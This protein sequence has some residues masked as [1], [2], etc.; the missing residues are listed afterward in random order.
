M[1]A[2]QSQFISEAEDKV[3]VVE[4]IPQSFDKKAGLQ[5]TERQLTDESFSL[6]SEYE[7]NGGDKR[8]SDD[9]SSP[10][11]SRQGFLPLRAVVFES[12]DSRSINSNEKSIEHFKPKMLILSSSP[13]NSR[14][15]DDPKDGSLQKGESSSGF[16]PKT[17]PAEKK[18]PLAPRNQNKINFNFDK[19][20]LA[21]RSEK[22]A[23]SVLNIS[24]TLNLP[25]DQFSMKISSVRSKNKNLKLS[26]I[27][28]PIK[29]PS[30]QAIASSLTFDHLQ[31]S[32]RYD[33]SI[34]EILRQ[35]DQVIAELRAE[36]DVL[37]SKNK[38]LIT[39]VCELRDSITRL[40]T[41]LEMA[42]RSNLELRHSDTKL[43]G[44]VKVCS[45]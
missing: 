30:E 16:K 20:F 33:P 1:Y 17:N 3:I 31:G 8:D 7:E 36:V 18:V 37:N 39:E 21:D 4:D 22:M 45:S 34:E 44:Q 15:E 41:Q 35:K 6:S 10:V 9:R 40:E 38:S 23:Q 26:D 27:E 25:E 28:M 43:V 12:E 11:Q 24:P 14:S 13:Q 5:K 29:T 32:T 19:G 42:T 2:K